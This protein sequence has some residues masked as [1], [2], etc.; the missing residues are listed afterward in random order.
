M[1]WF[2]I[3]AVASFCGVALAWVFKGGVEDDPDGPTLEDV[4]E[5]VRLH[6]LHC[7]LACRVVIHPGATSEL[8]VC[9]AGR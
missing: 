3:L 4:D 1:P 5:F 8:D 2:H 9:G 6:N 7:F